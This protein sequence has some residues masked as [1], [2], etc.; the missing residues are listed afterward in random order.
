[1]NRAAALAILF[2]LLAAGCATTPT[3]LSSPPTVYETGVDPETWVDRTQLVSSSP[4][5][6]IMNYRSNTT[7]RSWSQT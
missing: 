5:C 2:G 1:M 6:T 7:T 4:E 3:E